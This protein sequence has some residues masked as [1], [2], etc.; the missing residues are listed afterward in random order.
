MLMRRSPTD[1]WAVGAFAAAN[2]R[3]PGAI[4]DSAELKVKVVPKV[5]VL[6]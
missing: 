4:T 5:R 3:M 6:C 1:R 2:E